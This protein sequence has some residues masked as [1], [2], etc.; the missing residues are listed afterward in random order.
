MSCALSHLEPEMPNELRCGVERISS[1]L[2]AWS[3]PRIS[4]G[5]IRNYTL[6]HHEVGKENV[7]KTISTGKE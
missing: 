4:N 5:V 1:V 6:Q 7:I 2:C 3:A